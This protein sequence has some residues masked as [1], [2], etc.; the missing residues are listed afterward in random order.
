MFFYGMS[1]NSSHVAPA[2]LGSVA[3]LGAGVWKAARAIFD[4]SLAQVSTVPDNAPVFGAIVLG[5]VGLGWSIY[6]AGPDRR[7]KTLTDEIATLQD[8][9]RRRTAEIRE[10][11]ATI[12]ALRKERSAFQAEIGRLEGLVAR[13]Q[14]QALDNARQHP[15]P[16]PA[17]AQG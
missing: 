14:A 11:D 5:V 2:V 10:Q 6:S 4:P 9:L 8:Q 12:D 16:P 15:A 3:S 7:V 13:S 1:E 17:P